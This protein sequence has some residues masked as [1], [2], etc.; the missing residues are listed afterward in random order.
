MTQTHDFK[1]I[2]NEY[3]IIF[4]LFTLFSFDYSGVLKKQQFKTG[5][6]HKSALKIVAVPFSS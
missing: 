5:Y 3:I 1:F 4:D 2:Y 6:S